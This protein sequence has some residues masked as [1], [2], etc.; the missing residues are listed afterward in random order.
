MPDPVTMEEWLGCLS[1]PEYL[2]KIPTGQIRPIVGPIIWIDGNGVK[3]SSEEYIDKWGIDP[4]PA[5]AA[6]KEYRKQHGGGVRA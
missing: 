4:E 5:W 2:S 1:L 6:I 3:L